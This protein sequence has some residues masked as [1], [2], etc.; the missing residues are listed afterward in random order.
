M[1]DSPGL[2]SAAQKIGGLNTGLFSYENQ[3]ET[4]R[5]LIEALKKDSGTVASLL[6][7]SPLSGQFGMDNGAEKLKDWVD[8]SLL[9]SFDAVAKYFYLALT[10]GSVTS[11]GISF[12]VFTPNP[13]LLK[14]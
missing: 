3:A 7:A 14:K 4:T 13:P 10:S 11:D 5:A 2:T 12:K 9:P 8:F 6:A 1:R